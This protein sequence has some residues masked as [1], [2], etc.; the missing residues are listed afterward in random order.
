ME[1]IINHVAFILDA[2]GSMSHLS[3]NLVK[4]FDNQIKH[5]AELS[6]KVDQETRCTVYLFDNR[7]RNIIFDKDVLRLPSLK[8][9]YRTG[10]STALI[11]ATLKGIDDLKQSC[12]L[13]G[14]HAFLLYVLTDGGENCNGDSKKLIRTI[15]ELPDNWTIATF[16]PSQIEKFETQKHGF[17]KE[18]IAIWSTDS[19]G[20]DD[21]GDAITTSTTNYMTARSHGIRSVKNLFSL[22]TS[23]LTDSVVKSKLTELKSSEY[24]LLPVGKESPIKEFVIGFTKDYIPGSAYYQLSKSE[25][26]QASKQICVQNKKNGKIYTGQYARDMLGLPNS[27]VKVSPVDHTDFNIYIQSL[28]INRKLMVGTHV[29]VLN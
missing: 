3:D 13:Y 28:S 2:S 21:V 12:Q 15:S 18:N 9:L 10:G 25:K 4:V 11:D 8:T 19:A 14:E 22:N 20:M 16:V 6:K 1:N 5:L 17:P 7:V 29:L 26:V 27:E 24:S 23:K